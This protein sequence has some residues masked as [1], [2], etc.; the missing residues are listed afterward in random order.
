MIQPGN[1]EDLPK[2]EK[3]QVTVGDF[4][5]D[6]KSSLKL[7]WLAGKNGAGRKIGE[8]SIH[9]PG[10]ALAGFY[11]YFAN[12]RIQVFGGAEN[13]YLK[14]LSSIKRRE[15]T[16]KY[17]DLSFPC[18]LF[19]RNITP[20]T[21]FID[22]CE[23]RSIP[24]FVSSMVTYNLTNGIILYLDRI[25]SPSIK[26]IGNLV[27]VYGT[28]IIIRGSSGI[29]KS[30]CALALV[31]RGSA[32]VA[33][34]LV[35]IRRN[36]YSIISGTVADENMMGFMEI[37]GLGII[38]IINMFGI[39]AY[40]YQTEINLVVTLKNWDSIGTIDRTGLDMDTYRFLD[41]DMPHITIPVAPGRET[42]NLIEVAAQEF[43]MRNLGIHSGKVLNESL[44][45]RMSKNKRFG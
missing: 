32:L 17:L 6:N 25:L 34:D 20:D 45:R 44:I 31:R 42:A 5:L 14:S 24:L 2:T 40:K 1:P 16:E 36:G 19:A 8:A 33:D 13:A 39:S 12:R 3:T 10:L 26:L 43:R 7:R 18:I 38:N 41:V 22:L 23:K 29:G 30:E 35:R 4:F 11:D 21:H 15:S 37:R 28:G 27:D 9:R